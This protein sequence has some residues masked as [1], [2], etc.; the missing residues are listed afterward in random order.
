MKESGLVHVRAAQADSRLENAYAVSDMEVPVDF[1]AALEPQPTVKQ[2]FET[3]NK[4]KESRNS[5]AAMAIHK[6]YINACS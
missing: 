1:L 5:A 2:F 6:I 3:L 4:R